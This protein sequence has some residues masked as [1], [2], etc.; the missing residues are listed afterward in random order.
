MSDAIEKII[1]ET[2]TRAEYFQTVHAWP[3]NDK[4]DYNGWLSNFQDKNELKIACMLL[5]FFIYYP[6]LMV[7][8]M[9]KTAIGNAGY[10]LSRAISDWQHTDFHDRCIY[11]FI[12]G[13]SQNPTDSGRIFLRKLRDELGIPESR[14]IEYN[15]I[16]E[17]LEKAK[18]QT[19]VILV[20]DII[21]S[22]A[23]CDKAWNDN[24]FEYNGKTLKEISENNGHVFA[25]SPLIVNYIGFHRIIKK[26]SN[27]ILTPTHIL[28]VEYN[29]FK[30]DC[31]CW[32]GDLGLFNEGVNF[33][34]DKSKS[35]GIPITGGNH[36]QDAMGF[37]GQGL[38]LAF[39]HSVP[40]AIPSFFY[41][42]VDGWVPLLKKTYQR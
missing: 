24:K 13:E 3:L 8:H 7:N 32:K 25:Y 12:P 30:E 35:L 15:D 40:D 20:D 11:S 27:L 14:I 36:P 31:F 42:C 37:G 26:C 29:L 17:A 33:I 23:Q 41:W 9:L 1:K 38:A 34:L 21:G 5:D 28:G 19:P 18:R 4:L 6:D 39:E 10:Q 16:P 22:G 2:K